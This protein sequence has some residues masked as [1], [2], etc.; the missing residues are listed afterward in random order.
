MVTRHAVTLVKE[1]CCPII[2]IT[3]YHG[4]FVHAMMASAWPDI[5]LIDNA[6]IEPA[7]F[8][9]SQKHRVVNKAE[10]ENFL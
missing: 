4:D 3:Q 1:L 5:E 2:C 8:F 7:V 10:V 9:E 6:H